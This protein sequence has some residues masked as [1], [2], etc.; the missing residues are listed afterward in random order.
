MSITALLAILAV[1]L[2]L[3]A[4]FSSSETALMR[5]SPYR[6]R[7]LARRGNLGARLAEKM[8]RRPD[9]LIGLILAGNNAVN[10]AAS[11]IATIIALRVGGPEAVAVGAVILTLVVLIFSETAPKTLAALHPEKIALPAAIVYYPLLYI[12]YPIV[13]TVNLVANGL[14]R[15][16]GIAH[17]DDKINA[18]SGEE[19]RAAV[20]ESSTLLPARRQSM[21]LRILDL[22]KVTAE[23]I[24][25]PRNEI[26]SVDLDDEWEFIVSQ[27]RRARHTRLPLCR[28]GLDNVIGIL[29]L[30][31]IATALASGDLT[32]ELL[33]REA[34]PPYFVPEDTPLNKQL[35]NMQTNRQRMGLVVDEYGDIQGLITL[36]D[37]LGEIVGEFTTGAFGR[38]ELAQ[39]QEDGRYVVAGT[40]NLRL[41]NRAMGWKLPAGGAKTV[42]G[43]ILETLETIPEAGRQFEIAGYPMEV[44][45]TQDNVV[46][47]VS[48]APA[49][50]RHSKHH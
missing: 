13:W 5:I 8:L 36:D 25:I 24:M 22:E 34:L 40:T 2:V 10:V 15:L 4:F 19:L 43:L 39:E 32:P 50:A 29:H 26:V 48:I 33:E 45:R 7:A 31:R 49:P 46:H 42:N 44:M 1:L 27:L 37:L 38:R 18:M 20:A 41:L 11:S 14:L 35:V 30:R 28:E 9:R 21:L 6:L 16:L 17:V 47:T 23:D 3:S 12:F